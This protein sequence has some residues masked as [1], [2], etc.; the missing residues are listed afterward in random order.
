M[1]LC[2]R[3]HI[4]CLI[5]LALLFAS[6]ENEEP[7]RINEKTLFMYLPWSS[8]LTGHFY[9]NI[10][11]MEECISRKGLNN[12]KVIV[13]ISTDDTEATMF[14]I[15]YKKGKCER[16]TLKNYTNP[17]FTTSE[18]ITSI[19]N[20]MKTFAPAHTYAM[21]VGSHG[22]GW[23]PV[24]NTRA[25]SVSDIK[26]HWEYEGVPLTRYFGGTTRE[27]QTDV[28]AFALGIADAGI[29]MEYI[30][31]DDCYM[32]SIEVAYEL[33]D[34][35]GYLIGSTSEMMAYGMPY[36]T[37]G[38]YLLGKPDYEAIC[39]EFYAFY[40]M[41]KYPYGTLAVTDC[42]ELDNMAAI[43]KEINSRYVFDNS[44]TGSIQRLDGYTP[45]IFFDYGDYVE[46]LCKEDPI[47]LNEFREQLNRTVPYKT[48]TEKFYSAVTRSAT[49][50]RTF[51]GITT[52]DPSS[53]PVAASKEDTKWYK[54]TH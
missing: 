50:I 41:Y 4:L 51:S 53:N 36:A 28:S 18:G 46:R 42:S 30:L 52:S 13:F 14:E 47:L 11:D 38:G 2:K 21:T 15:I 16:K 3:F 25:R 33:K 37:V 8:N 17:S 5:A 10:S 12:E 32:S 40:S 1:K 49:P 31:F 48:K 9:T 7:E 19:L 54:V 6:C 22:M 44:L 24:D 39:D 45:V 35:T 20:D 29:K 27:Y 26:K 43:M 34:V 23:L